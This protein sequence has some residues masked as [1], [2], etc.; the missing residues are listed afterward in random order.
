[1]AQA[2]DIALKN[3]MERIAAAILLG[4]ELNLPNNLKFPCG[5]CNKSVQKNQNALQCD[6]CDKWVHRKCEG[7]S[8]EKYRS[9]SETDVQFHCLYCTMR[10]NH[11]NIPFTISDNFELG[12]INNSDE[13]VHKYQ[14][15][16]WPIVD[17]S[18]FL[19]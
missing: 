11:E 5:I 9:F 19:K 18:T 16:F 10:E 17:I 8:P 13:H 3:N 6:T 7:M 15:P 12:N 14:P 4:K 2:I 1:M